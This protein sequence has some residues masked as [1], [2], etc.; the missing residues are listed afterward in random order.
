MSVQ[1]TNFTL[2]DHDVTFSGPV[3]S[4]A[5][6]Q[7]RSETQSATGPSG[8]IAL[9]EGPTGA[10]LVTTGPQGNPAIQTGPRS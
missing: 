9:A 4:I 10:T 7:M 2:V 6:A 1:I 8:S 3:G 5:A